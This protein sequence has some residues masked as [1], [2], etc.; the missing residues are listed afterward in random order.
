MELSDVS[1]ILLDGDA[2]DVKAG[3]SKKASRLMHVKDETDR[4]KAESLASSEGT[5]QYQELTHL[6][7]LDLSTSWGQ[8]AITCREETLTTQGPDVN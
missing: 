1:N 6:T 3:A 8:E 5:S 4:I 7:H 2:V